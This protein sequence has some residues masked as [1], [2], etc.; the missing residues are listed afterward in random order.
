MV[1][2]SLAEGG[3][4]WRMLS[5]WAG[6]CASMRA[7]LDRDPGEG[8]LLFYAMAS[9][10]VWFAGMLLML[11]YGQ[12]MPP[13]SDEEF[14]GHASAALGAALFVR[15]L[16]LYGLAAVA[17]AVARALGGGASWRGSRAAMFWAALVAAP[18]MLA[19]TMASIVLTDDAVAAGA[20]AETLGSLVFARV[21]APCIAETHGFASA[22][23]GLAVVVITAALLLAVLSVI[24]A[25]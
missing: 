20:A 11:R 17:H 13:L 10:L 19:M 25:L 3:L 21:A 15:P 2:R 18:M 23:R 12:A 22:W 1:A 5:A 6:L 7:E 8:R 24:L 4:L 16:A 9:G 14:L